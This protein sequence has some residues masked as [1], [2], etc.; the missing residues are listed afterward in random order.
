MQQSNEQQS[1][2]QPDQS[3]ESFVYLNYENEDESLKL[4]HKR[5]EH[6]I[7]I[8]SGKQKWILFYFLFF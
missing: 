8:N 1:G 4:M 2:K 7:N 5:S 6:V 3:N